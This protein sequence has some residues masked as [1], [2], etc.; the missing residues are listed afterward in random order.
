[1]EEA[2]QVELELPDKQRIV[3]DRA[4]LAEPLAHFAPETP[5][6]FRF[7]TNYRGIAP[8]VADQVDQQQLA[9]ILSQAIIL[10]GG[11]LSSSYLSSQVA[12][13]IRGVAAR[14]LLPDFNC[15][16]SSSNSAW[17]GGS[18]MSHLPSFGH[19][20]VSVKDWREGGLAS[21]LKKCA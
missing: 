14:R 16:E 21:V 4:E 6:Y 1:M 3:V 2:S 10:T 18:L 7:P 9:P 13:K 11:H 15:L 20:W 19:F 5:S 17:I 8:I 12:A